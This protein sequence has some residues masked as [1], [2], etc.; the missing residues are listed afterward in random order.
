MYDLQWVEEGELLP[1]YRADR[2]LHPLH[3]PPSKTGRISKARLPPRARYREERIQ[4]AFKAANAP[5]SRVPTTW[6]RPRGREQAEGPCRPLQLGNSL[7]GALRT[8]FQAILPGYRPFH[9]RR[10]VIL[11]RGVNFPHL[12]RRHAHLKWSLQ[13]PR[14]LAEHLPQRGKAIFSF[15]ARASSFQWSNREQGAHP[16]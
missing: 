9:G 6:P 10:G 8:D 2:P 14:D 11:H 12:R 1:K 3:V 15:G 13:I 5:L 16:P 7:S 4:H